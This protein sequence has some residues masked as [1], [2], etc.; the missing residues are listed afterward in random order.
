MRSSGAPRLGDRVA[1]SLLRGGARACG[2]GTLGAEFGEVARYLVQQRVEL[3]QILR[4]EVRE[5]ESFVQAREAVQPVQQRLRSR[6][7]V[8]TV[9]AAI[10]R[11]LLA[12]QVAFLA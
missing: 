10:S 4:A 1:G 3:L 2:S 5:D 6:C 11:V 8:D 7:Q 12:P 9:R